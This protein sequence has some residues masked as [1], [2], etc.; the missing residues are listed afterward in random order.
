VTVVEV[1]VMEVM[2]A[3]LMVENSCGS[4]GDGEGD[5]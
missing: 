5:G 3:K 4:G 2:M 1:M